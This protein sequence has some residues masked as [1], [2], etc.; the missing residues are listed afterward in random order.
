MAVISAEL[1]KIEDVFNRLSWWQKFLLFIEWGGI[2]IG[3]FKPAG[4]SAYMEFYIIYC[5]SCK[6]IKI[7]HSSGIDNQKIG[8]S[9]WMNKNP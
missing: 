3:W 1:P 4:Y 8:C 2:P 9:C 6:K 5:S 7:V